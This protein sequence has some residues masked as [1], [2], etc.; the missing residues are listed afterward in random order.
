MK[1]KEKLQ[2]TPNECSTGR[3]I[4]VLAVALTVGFVLGSPLSTFMSNREDFFMGVAYADLFGVLFF[5]PLFVGMVLA[6]KL[7]GKTSLKEFILGVGGKVNKKECLLVFGLFAGGFVLPHL[8]ILNNIHLR[9]V[10]VGEYGFLV[11]FMLLTAWMQTTWEELLFRGLFLRWACKNK[12]GYTKKAMLA[13]V[14]SSVVFA[15]SHVTNPE[16][17]SQSG[18]DMLL[19]VLAYTIP[20]FVCFLADLH[21]GSLLPGIIIHWINNFVLFTVISSE[22]SVV[23]VPTLLAD[24]TPNS[25]AWSLGSTALAYLPVLVYILLD[26]RKKRKAAAPEA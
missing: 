14:L 17:T 4:A 6:L 24:S 20:G 8:L 23:S 1:N 5:V 11:L 13:A 3:W 10:D 12:V 26:I 18:I 15:L 9:G 25:A 16:V 19:A 22:V 2:I 7:L 21:F